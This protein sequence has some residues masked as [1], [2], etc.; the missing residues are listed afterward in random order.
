MKFFDQLA[1]PQ[2]EDMIFGKA[3]HPVQCGFDLVIGDAIVFPEVNYTLPP[4]EVTESNTDEIIETYEFIVTSILTRM[5]T[6]EVPGVVLEF[7]H[8]PQMTNIVHI[9]GEVTKLTKRLMHEF[10][11]KYGLKSALRVTICDTRHEKHPPRIRSGKAITRVLESFEENARSGADLLSIESVGGKELADHALLN[12]DIPQ[13]LVSLGTLAPRDMHFLWS[14]ITSIASRH[15]SVA[16]GDSACGIANTAMVL[17]DQRYIPGVLA[18][19]V[20]AMSAVRSLVAYEEGAV[21]P[22]KDC[23]YE[24]PIIKAITGCPISMEGKTSA[25]AH[26][27]H[28]GNVAAALCDLWSNESVQ[29]VK[30][31]SGYA[32]EVFAEILTYDCRLMNQALREGSAKTLQSLM[33]NSDERKSVHALIIAPSSAHRIAEAIVA[34]RNDFQRVHRAAVTA[35]EIIRGA[36]DSQ[37]IEL[38][39]RELA[40]LDI[41]E[42]QLLEYSDEDSVVDYVRA[43]CG[44]MVLW[45]EYGL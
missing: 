13:L 27:S 34:E 4:M 10:Y 17:A 6:L 45:D 8:L 31:L 1:Y 30:L 19:V 36:V 41:I 32:P 20:R 40:Y 18:A 44:N 22:S 26:F 14:N 15:D 21:G 23:A 42:S 3:L 43:T 28:V 37:F 39:D 9:G 5:Q 12:A 25:C 33:V 24:G 35:C 16:A 2:S 29:N 38:P 11:E 7:E